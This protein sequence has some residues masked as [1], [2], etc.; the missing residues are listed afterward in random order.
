MTPM[1]IKMAKLRAMKKTKPK[2]GGCGGKKCSPKCQDGKGPKL[3]KVVEVIK[4]GVELVKRGVDFGVKNKEKILKGLKTATEVAGVAG[5][6]TGSKALKNIGNLR[7]ALGKGK[8]KQVGEGPKLDKFVGAVKKGA[9]YVKRGIQYGLKNKEKILKGAKDATEL[10][11]AAGNYTGNNALKKVGTYRQY[12]GKGKKGRGIEE[13][14][15]PEENAIEAPVQAIPQAIQQSPVNTGE[16]EAPV[17]YY[18]NSSSLFT[19][20]LVF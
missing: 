11:A 15:E 14:P 12:L 10:A 1:Q 8:K 3:D 4:K 18:P 20:R 13:S 2:K 16:L 6:I 5:N 19:G 7:G 17:V 9:N